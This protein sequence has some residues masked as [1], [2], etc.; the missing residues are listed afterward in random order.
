MVLYEHEIETLNKIELFKK[1]Y[2]MLGK[3]AQ[4]HLHIFEK[5][6]SYLPIQ[7]LPNN[8]VG[9]SFR[10]STDKI[11]LQLIYSNKNRK[12][13]KGDVLRFLF[14]RSV[15]EFKVLSGSFKEENNLNTTIKILSPEDYKSF[16]FDRLIGIEIEST[17]NEITFIKDDLKATLDYLNISD[18]LYQS[19]VKKTASE[20]LVE[21][22]KVNPKSE[23]LKLE[24]T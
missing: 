24:Y 15:V 2:D 10:I 12:F 4:Y 9:F 3:Y 14:D 5:G 21:F 8:T 20:I 19:V 11:H 17:K 7:Y 23:F 22:L 6:L 18:N 13:Y 16:L 1:E